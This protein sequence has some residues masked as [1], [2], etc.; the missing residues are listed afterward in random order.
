GAADYW[1]EKGKLFQ[2]AAVPLIQGFD[3]Y[4]TLVVGF[5]VDERQAN[6]VRQVTGTD[7]SF[8][9]RSEGRLHL[10]ASTFDADRSRQLE[11]VLGER[12]DLVDRVLDQGQPVPEADLELDS[13]RWRAYLVPL[14]GLDDRVVAGVLGVTS[15]DEALAGYRQIQK[16]LLAAGLGALLAALALSYALS[17]RTLKPMRNLT[18][19]A[20]KAAQGDY[21][22]SIAVARRDEVG[23][24]G[25]AFNSLLSDLREK[26]DMEVYVAGLSRHLPEPARA[27]VSAPADARDLALLALELRRYAHP[28]TAK[29]PAETLER[30]SRDL[31]RITSV[32]LS[33]GGKVES[34]AGH[35]VLLRFDGVQA[36]RKAVAAAGE[37]YKLLRTPEN[38]FDE[39]EPPVIALTVGRT[40]SGSTAWGEQPSSILLGLPVQQLESLMREGAPGDFL[41][42]RQA[43]R[44]LAPVLA[45]AG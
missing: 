32:S 17:R 44:E 15:L 16:G 6:E 19:A 31:R 34:V 45:A 18:S 20:E 38:A 36:A 28:R 10:A 3:F 41:L 27:A 1:T 5:S 23:R 9:V 42:S 29:E 26:K 11:K 37:L 13:A 4:G 12:S 40:T 2:V 39:A 8:L 22:H 21:S 14:K 7:L 35:R 25:E 43:Q 30:L 24:L 33:H